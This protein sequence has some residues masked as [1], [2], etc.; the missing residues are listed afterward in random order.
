MNGAVYGAFGEHSMRMYE[1]M[2]KAA[3][4]V[5]IF[6]LFPLAIVTGFAMS[7]AITSVAPAL[8]T[9]FGGQQSAR[10]IHFFVAAALVGFLLL[11]V[12]MVFVSGFVERMRGM[13]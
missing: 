6:L 12:T 8:V 10:T 13:L 4:R 5:V 1:P 2:Q 11:H 9:V 7:P 3:Y